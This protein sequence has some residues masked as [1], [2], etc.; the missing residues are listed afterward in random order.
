MSNKGYRVPTQLS[1]SEINKIR[2]RFFDKFEQFKLMPLEELKNKDQNEK[3]STTDKNALNVAI[4]YL[5]KEQA[6]NIVETE[7]NGINEELG[8]TSAPTER[9]TTGHEGEE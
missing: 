9:S 1:K 6:K 3:M 8:V 2:N 5:M 4:D 7:E